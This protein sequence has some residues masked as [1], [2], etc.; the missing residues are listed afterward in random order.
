MATVRVASDQGRVFVFAPE[1][2]TIGGGAEGVRNTIRSL[3]AGGFKDL[4]L[5][6]SNTRYVDSAGLAEVLVCH[7]TTN[8]RGG[9]LELNRL[10]GGP[11]DLFDITKLLTVFHLGNRDIDGLPTVE[12]SSDDVSSLKAA[13]A[14]PVLLSLRE[15]RIIVELGVQEG[16]YKVRSGSDAPESLIIATPHVLS[17]GTRTLLNEDLREFEELLNSSR[18]TE[19]DIQKFL[20]RKPGFVLGENYRELHS[21]VLLERE[22]DGPL[23]PDFVLEPFDCELCDL[24]ELKLPGEP[25]VVGTRNRKRFSHAVQSA[26]AQLRAYRDYFE[27]RSNRERIFQQ[28]GIKAYRPRLS[29]VIGRVPT[30]DPIEYRRIA[31]GARDVEIVTYD[32]LLA[33]A[34]RFLIV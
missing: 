29:V 22:D 17:T 26:I 23:I 27:D 7:T 13:E 2:I 21:K 20:E 18:T 33:R 5:D 25:V 32:D 6:M 15:N 11:R 3:L 1:R 24:L 34:K 8:N 14:L 19:E 4:A 30:L 10:A 16:V 31:D 9:R 12:V 28:R